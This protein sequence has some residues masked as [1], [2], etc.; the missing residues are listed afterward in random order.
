[1]CKEYD[2]SKRCC[3]CKE[4]PQGIPGPQG[5]Q[6]IQGVPGS[7]GSTGPQGIQGQQ[8]L[9]GPPGKDCDNSN[10]NQC[11]CPVAYFNIYS[12]VPQQVQPYNN[13]GDV[14]LF[15]AQNAVTPEFDFSMMNVNGDIKFLKHGVYSLSWTLQARVA[16]PIPQPVPSWS[17]GLWSN[18]VLIPGSIFS[19]FTQAPTDDACHSSAEVIVE[20]KS[21]DLVKL[22]NTS[23]NVIDLNPSNVGNAFPITIAS[24]NC[25]LLKEL[26]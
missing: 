14:V 19:G 10:G 13:V 20:M 5:A 6:G 25:V 9:Q 24:L 3:G 15:N 12:N 7:Q 18:G 22:R 11:D 1:M 2:E 21:N 17:F 23:I 16:P 8:G 4:G 26:P